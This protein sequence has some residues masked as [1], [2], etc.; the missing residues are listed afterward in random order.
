MRW[1]ALALALA[2]AAA[3]AEEVARI[4]DVPV[5]AREIGLGEPATL[6]AAANA[7]R[8]RA[9][10]SALQW[11]VAEHKIAA[12]DA[13]LAAYAQWNEE[14]QRRDKARRAQ[15]LEQIEAALARPNLAAE[16]REQLL[17]ERDTY[18]QVARHDAE[19]EAASR[20][21]GS[22]QR[23]WGPWITSFKANKALYDK[24]GGRVGL[25]KFGPEPIGALE[26][27]LRE[28]EKAGALRIFDTSLAKEFWAW[29]AVQPRRVAKPAEIDFTYY[30]LRP[31]DELHGPRR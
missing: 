16:Q 6:P 11:F 1:L 21:P 30:W 14:F 17:R 28:R 27:L 3:Q 13:D 31:F 18:R 15:R 23:V 9:M 26:T 20:D 19:R 2:G 25:T 7:L 8:Q 4:D 22:R 12:T 24:Y 5:R 10:K 29:Y